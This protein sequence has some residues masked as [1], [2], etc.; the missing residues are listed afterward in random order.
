MALQRDES[1]GAKHL[2][3]LDWDFHRDRQRLGALWATGQQITERLLKPADEQMLKR[4]C[5]W[6]A[7]YHVYI[8]TIYN[9]WLIM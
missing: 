1:W 4:G 6:M 2:A 9:I 7:I 5:F 8:Y 3:R